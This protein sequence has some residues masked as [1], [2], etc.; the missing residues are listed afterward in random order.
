[1][2]FY[3]RAWDR[4][5]LFLALSVSF[6]AFFFVCFVLRLSESFAACLC[7]SFCEGLLARA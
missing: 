2:W 5:C 7:V 6:F 4:V 3:V 1:V